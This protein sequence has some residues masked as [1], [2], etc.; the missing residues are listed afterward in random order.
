M[1]YRANAEPRAVF[2]ALAHHLTP[3]FWEETRQPLNRPG[4]PGLSGETREAYGP[5]R[6]Q[7]IAALVKTL[8]THGYR[9]SPVRRVYIS[10]NPDSL[11]NSDRSAS[12]KGK[13]AFCKLR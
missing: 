8:K 5:V 4:A 6:G 1:A 3:E 7:R 2:T 10:R 9:V 13:T 12:Q 11:P